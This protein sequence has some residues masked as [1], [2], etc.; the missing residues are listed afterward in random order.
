MRLFSLTA[1]FGA[2]MVLGGARPA[3]AQDISFAV[4]CV[5]ATSAQMDRYAM[6]GTEAKALLWRA[7]FLSC[8]AAHI[9]DSEV[10]KFQLQ[11]EAAGLF[12]RAHELDATLPEAGPWNRVPVMAPRK[13]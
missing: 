7:F 9:Q 11:E 13:I 6:A 12:F 8:S 5:A 2:M 1:V 3:L 4:R 10:M